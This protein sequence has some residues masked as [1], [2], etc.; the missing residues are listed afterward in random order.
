MGWAWVGFMYI[1][2]SLLSAAREEAVSRAGNTGR[3]SVA[4]TPY[5]ASELCWGSALC[6]VVRLVIAL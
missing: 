1:I 6:D 2:F 3:S 4:F 5:K